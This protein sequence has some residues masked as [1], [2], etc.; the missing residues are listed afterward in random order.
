MGFEMNTSNDK[1]KDYNL[2]KFKIK[3]DNKQVPF[4]NFIK[5]TIIISLF[6]ALYMLIL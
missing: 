3:I 6:A 2:P 1:Y 4:F 5:F